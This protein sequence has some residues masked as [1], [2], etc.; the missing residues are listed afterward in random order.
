MSNFAFEFILKNS[1]G[2]TLMVPVNVTIVDSI[3]H[4]SCNGNHDMQL[5]SDR[6]TKLHIIIY[7]FHISIFHNLSNPLRY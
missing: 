5:R 2:V 7:I 1:C 6:K 4:T 3:K